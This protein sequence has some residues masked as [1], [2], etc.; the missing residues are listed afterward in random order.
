[1]FQTALLSSLLRR[2]LSTKEVLNSLS[3]EALD[4][5]QDLV[6]Y[7]MFV[8]L[9]TVLFCSGTPG[10][11]VILIVIVQSENSWWSWK[12]NVILHRGWCIK[13]NSC[14]WSLSIDTTA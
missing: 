10:V 14:C 8:Q 13:S 12:V 6:L 4:G 2:F 11:A 3:S 7:L 9:W 1:M 5:N